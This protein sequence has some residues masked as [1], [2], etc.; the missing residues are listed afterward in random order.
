MKIYFNKLYKDG[1]KIYYY[2]KSDDVNDYL[3]ENNTTNKI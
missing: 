3:G 1:R 2:N